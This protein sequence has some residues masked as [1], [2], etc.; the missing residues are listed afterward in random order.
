MSRNCSSLKPIE[1]AN[2]SFRRC[3]SLKEKL[4]LAAPPTVTVLGVLALFKTPSWQR[5]L[6]AS[7]ASSAFL[8]YLDPQHE[9]NIAQKLILPQLMGAI[10]GLLA[11]LVLSAGDFS[12]AVAIVGVI[13]LDIVHPPA[14]STCLVW[15]LE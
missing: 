4:L 12:G 10:V 15:R 14:V 5:L 2:R 1:G 7:L 6:F 3:L 9:V 13:V 8:I 11:D